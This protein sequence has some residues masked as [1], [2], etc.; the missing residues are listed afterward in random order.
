MNYDNYCLFSR[1]SF[2]EGMA[3]TLDIGS[4]LNSYNTSRTEKDADA[5]AICSDWC[6]V[7]QDMA[8]ALKHGK[9]E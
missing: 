4:N 5:K 8:K 2:L 1:P 6:M 9:Q 3:R 7:G